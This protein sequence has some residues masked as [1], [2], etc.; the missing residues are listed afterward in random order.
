[1][2]SRLLYVGRMEATMNKKNVKTATK[3]DARK[4]APAPR[5]LT[6]EQLSDIAGGEYRVIPHAGW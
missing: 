1:V 4:N 6:L 2:A 5:K 3:T